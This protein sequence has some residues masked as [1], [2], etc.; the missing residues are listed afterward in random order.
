MAQVQPQHVSPKANDN[1][2]A[3]EEMLMIS[4]FQW[5]KLDRRTLI[6]AAAAAGGITTILDMP[7]NS[8][9]PTVIVTNSL[10]AQFFRLANP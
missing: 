5:G 9:P 3:W 8:L 7:L 10:P 2:H 4:G 1:S 6:K